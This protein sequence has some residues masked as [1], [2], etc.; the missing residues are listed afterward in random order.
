MKNQPELVWQVIF[1]K[2]TDGKI[3]VIYSGKEVNLY[4]VLAALDLEK[5]QL[6]KTLLDSMKQGQGDG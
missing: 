4:E 1:Q 5:A 6:Q 3:N 2:T